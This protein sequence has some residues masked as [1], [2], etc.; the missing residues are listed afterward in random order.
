M[1]IVSILI[2]VLVFFVIVVLHEFGHFIVAKL[3]GVKVNQFAIGM[4]PV[5]LKTAPWR[6]R[7]IRAQIRVLSGQS[8]CG[9]G[10]S[11]CWR[12]L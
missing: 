12:G 6:A 4:G 1:S 3:C 2:A 5:L 7:T 8:R 10:S 11:S 9:S